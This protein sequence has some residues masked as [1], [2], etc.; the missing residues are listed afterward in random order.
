MLISRCLVPIVLLDVTSAGSRWQ[1]VPVSED[2]CPFDDKFMDMKSNSLLQVGRWGNKVQSPNFEAAN[3][4]SEN[5]PGRNHHHK[6]QQVPMTKG[7]KAIAKALG[8]G[9]H[10]HAPDLPW[11]RKGGPHRYDAHAPDLHD[12]VDELHIVDDLRDKDVNESA[13]DWQEDEVGELGDEEASSVEASMHI[14]VSVMLLGFITFLMALIYFV[15][16]PDPEIQEAIWRLLSAT[17]SI[18]IAALIFSA[19]QE[20]M[21]HWIEGGEPHHGHEIGHGTRVSRDIL[22]VSFARLLILWLVLNVLVFCE[23]RSSVASGGLGILFGHMTAFAAFDAFGTLQEA[24]I[25][26]GSLLHSLGAITFSFLILGFMLEAVAWGRARMFPADRRR[27]AVEEAMHECRMLEHEIAGM[28][29]GLLISQS[30]RFAMSGYHP[31]LHSGDPKGTL[32]TQAVLLL[33]VIGC[34]AGHLVPLESHFDSW[35]AILLARMTLATTMAWCLLFWLQWAFW[36]NAHE[37]DLGYGDRM[38]SLIT[39]ALLVSTIGLAAIFI[40][41]RCD[42]LQQGAS[43]WSSVAVIGNALALVVGLAWEHI[44]HAAVEGAGDLLYMP[45]SSAMNTIIIFFLLSLVVFPAWWCIV[46]PHALKQR[47]AEAKSNFVFQ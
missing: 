24:D 1:A 2:A 40:V 37:A 36:R 41:Y 44:F 16:F 15:N 19:T 17:M 12:P 26:S 20:A 30:I 14:A 27:E 6:H 9:W 31:P 47:S 7:Q 38:T 29:L 3:E 11:T 34:A 42:S 28:V 33:A 8:W 25:F 18:F 32:G 43:R 10:R 23:K 35:R 22:I 45:V 39:K 5:P 21:A 4:S 13:Q 46:L